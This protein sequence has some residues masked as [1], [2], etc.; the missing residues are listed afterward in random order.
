MRSIFLVL[1]LASSF[2]AGADDGQL[3][4]IIEKANAGE[5][6]YQNYLG[7]LYQFG[8]GVEQNN[9][10]A[11]SWYQK[12]AD[13]GFPLAKVNL[14]YMYDEAQGVEQDK[15]K[16]VSLYMEAAELG[17]PRGMLNLGE[18]Y[19]KGDHVEQSNEKAYMWLDL[20]R[21][22]TQRSKD[23]QAKWASRAALDALKKNMS[24]QEIKNGKKLV[25]EWVQSKKK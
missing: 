25:K 11:I 15:E 14:G 19:R 22:F 6:N 10:A 18:M 23:K 16:A 4:E 21:L 8:E 9:N 13:Q 24:K 20:A 12:A 17:E 5:P 1:L 3:A 7:S 2:F